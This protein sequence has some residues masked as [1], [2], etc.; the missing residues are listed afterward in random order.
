MILDKSLEVDT[1]RSLIHAAVNEPLPSLNAIDKGL[2]RDV[3][4]GKQLYLYFH[5]TQ[6]VL[7]T[8]FLQL[9]VA[10][11]DD[12]DL[13]G[14]DATFHSLGGS[15]FL[16]PAATK[17]TLNTRIVVAVSP[18]LLQTPKRYIGAVYYYLGAG[19]ITQGTVTSGFCAEY[20]NTPRV[21]P[22]GIP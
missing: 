22:N 9:G 19:T 1:N 6:A 3:W 15:D 17:F 14:G 5:I 4:E 2:I 21:Y 7:G 10:E 13:G 20:P 18:R 12:G 8:D 16:V 11:D